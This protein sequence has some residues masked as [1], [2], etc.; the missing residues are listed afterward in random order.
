[1]SKIL[2]KMMGPELKVNIGYNTGMHEGKPQALS[3][4]EQLT[5]DINDLIERAKPG[6]SE[7]KAM[8]DFSFMLISSHELKQLR[9]QFKTDSGRKA[10]KTTSE[11]IQTMIGIK[12]TKAI[13]RIKKSD[14][15]YTHTMDY[16]NET[17]L[18]ERALDFTKAKLLINLLNHTVLQF[19]K[20]QR[21]LPK[22]II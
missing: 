2:P 21:Q 3:P 4:E 11:I 6:T 22:S 20:V 17:F 9:K 12:L 14:P 15:E 10:I 19:D 8:D 5:I 13:T 1:M 18:Q 16:L 7:R